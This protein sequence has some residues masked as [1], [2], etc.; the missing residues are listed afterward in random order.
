M[1]ILKEIEKILGNV[2]FAVVIILFFAVALTYGTFM[3]SYHG[4]EYANRLVY[5]SPWFMLIQAFMFLSIFFATTTRL[6]WRKA[7]A[8]FYVLHLGLLLIFIGSLVTYDSG[9]DGNVTL[10]PNEP[11]RL[12]KINEDELVVTLDKQQK[13]LSLPLPFKAGKSDLNQTWENITVEQYLPFAQKELKWKTGES[14]QS[15]STRYKLAND[16]FSE[17]LTLSLAAESAFESSMTLGL[18]NVHYLPSG[19]FACFEEKAKNKSAPYIIW[20]IKKTAC[21]PAKFKIKKMPKGQEII[22]AEYGNK[23]MVHFVP[24]MSPI[25]VFIDQEDKLKLDEES[26]IRLFHMDLFTSS[27]H[28]FVFGKSLA[29]FDK[30]LNEWVAKSWDDQKAEM[31]LPWMGFKIKIL[32]HH[33]DKFPIYEPVEALPVFDNNVIVEGADRA[34]RITLKEGSQSETFWLY[35]NAPLSAKLK[36]ETIRF[37]LQPKEITMPFEINLTK[38]KMDTDPG[39]NNP[40]SYESFVN[41]FD[42]KK[43]T[44]YHLYMNHPMKLDDMT[45]Y[46]ASYFDLGNNTFGSI[47]SV[48][49]DPGRW[50]KY[51]GCVLLILGS[52]WHFW[53]RRK[54]NW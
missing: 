32:E 26:N 4:A 52:T 21:L 3:E 15:Q 34:I 44:D 19:L 22:S 40:A 2:K 25:P 48:N 50:I 13:K 9:V 29:Y 54:I 17:E 47:L 41:V 24:T 28:L 10:V 38:F 20:D 33:D 42:G 30:G 36:N 7:L 12:I 53:L 16:N 11:A 1:T 49:Y 5:K 23:E 46:Q 43:N 27:P 51:F 18:L 14:G 31:E 39:T 8:G 6:P 45:F 35:K 37:S